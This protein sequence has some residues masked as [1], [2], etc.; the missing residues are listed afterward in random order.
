MDTANL[1]KELSQVPNALTLIGLALAALALMAGWWFFYVPR[2]IGVKAKALLPLWGLDSTRLPFVVH[3]TNINTRQFKIN[4]VGFET[5]GRYTN[6]TK[7]CSYELIVDIS[8]L[9]D[10]LLIMEAESTQL[11]FDGYKIAND[12]ANGLRDANL[13]LTSPKLKIWLY[14]THGIKVLVKHET[15]LSSRVITRINEG[16]SIIES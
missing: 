6:G 12:I 15:N 11:S 14:L 7:S 2:K 16:P 5:F 1:I 10:K 3:V 4:N 9:S 13:R 8:N